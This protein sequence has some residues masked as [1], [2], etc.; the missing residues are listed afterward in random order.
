MSRTAVGT[1]GALADQAA[2]YVEQG[3]VPAC[4]VAVARGG[5]LELF[6]AFGEATTST[7][8]AAYSATKPIVAAAAW[9]LVDRGSLA[10]DAA[11]EDLV[12]ELVGGP[13]RATIEQLLLHTAGFPN[14]PM[15]PEEGADAERR[16][17]RFATWKLEWEPGSRFAYHPSSAHWV[18]ADLIERLDGRDFRDAVEALVTRPM[19]LPRL[20]GIPPDEQE[21]IAPPTPVGSR[22][23]GVDD[24]ARHLASPEA[25]AAGVPGGGGIMTAADLAF[26]YQELLHNTHGLW[27]EP[28]LRDVTS[29]IR[30]RLVDPVMQVP[31]NR[32]LGLVVAGDDG[33]HV[34]RYACFGALCS[35]RAFGHAGAHG[36]VGWADPA[37]GVSFAFL[38]NGLH[39]DMRRTG[40]RAVEMSTLAAGV[41]AGT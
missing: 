4:Q 9:R 30:C 25:I 19:G 26:F 2:L 36:Q 32:T 21:G 11:V 27:S 31:V 14:A 7:R 20:L 22:P 18:L 28:T 38:H 34:L 35:P 6:E 3:A 10:V 15:H 17:K 40:A 13:G 12:P 33:K 23:L 41:A 29:N 5:K 8:F 16:R 24:P 39:G 37:S 1:W